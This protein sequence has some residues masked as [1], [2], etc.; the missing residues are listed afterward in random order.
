MIGALTAAADVWYPSSS[1]DKLGTTLRITIDEAV[2]RHPLIRV[3]HSGSPQRFTRNIVSGSPMGV[4]TSSRMGTRPWFG[5][6]V[7]V[8]PGKVESSG[9]DSDG[10]VITALGV[11]YPAKRSSDKV[12]RNGTVSDYLSAMIYSLGLTPYVEPSSLTQ[13]VPQGG[14][15]DWQVINELARLSG[16]DVFVTGSTVNVLSPNEALVRFFPEAALLVNATSKELLEFPDTMDRVVYSDNRLSESGSSARSVEPSTG[17]VMSAYDVS[18]P[19]PRMDGSITAR[20]LPTLRSKVGGTKRLADLPVS[21]N[22]SGP[23][24]VLVGAGKPVFFNDQGEQHWWLVESVTHTFVPPTG[25]HSMVATLRRSSTLV[26]I[27]PPLPYPQKNTLR[28][29]KNFC[30]CREYDPLLVNRW[31]AGYVTAQT[32]S[33]NTE[34]VYSDDLVVD[35]WVKTSPEYLRR[36]KDTTLAYSWESL[37]RW[38]ARG[39]CEWL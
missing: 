35:G 24:N 22:V 32:S 30:T 34:P 1:D 13:T 38:R 12:Y 26:D 15:T 10:T 18:G 33:I 21:A 16:M 14:R 29:R 4:N 2:N 27:G 5:Y 9:R 36:T 8:S 6:V 11:T 20:S 3:E 7:D 28:H 17:R 23:G 25:E 39:K 37:A 19:F 31:R